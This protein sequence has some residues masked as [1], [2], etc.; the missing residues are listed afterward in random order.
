LNFVTSI[1]VQLPLK[2][3]QVAKR[4]LGI[5]C[6]KYHY[7]GVVIVEM[8]Q[9][10]ILPVEEQAFLENTLKTVQF[11]F[12]AIN[13]QDYVSAKLE[14]EELKFSLNRLEDIQLKRERKEQLVNLIVDMQKRGINIDIARPSS[15]LKN[16]AENAGEKGPNKSKIHKKR[17]QA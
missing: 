2:S 6:Y 1:N 10:I 15:F 4:K 5:F 13:E 16:S 11:L 12:A 3:L 7:E 8:S 17:Q 14:M 9:K